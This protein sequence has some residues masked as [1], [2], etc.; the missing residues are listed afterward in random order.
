MTRESP[1]IGLRAGWKEAAGLAGRAPC[2]VIMFAAFLQ[3]SCLEPRGGC[4]ETTLTPSSCLKNSSIFIDQMAPSP[5]AAA[6]KE[7]KKL[8]APN[9]ILFSNSKSGGGKGKQVLEAMGAVIGAPPSS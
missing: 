6:V 4:Q 3:A 1:P 5:M 2:W 7:E 9:I 8:V